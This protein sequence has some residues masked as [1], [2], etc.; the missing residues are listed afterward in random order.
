[1]SIIYSNTVQSGISANAWVIHQNKD[2]F[3]EDAA[4]F[5]PERW[6]KEPDRVV[7][8]STLFQFVRYLLAAFSDLKTERNFLSFGAGSRY[9]IGRNKFAEALPCH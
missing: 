1:M 6:I 8:M 7:T 4:K 5:R 3:G 2:V 9:C